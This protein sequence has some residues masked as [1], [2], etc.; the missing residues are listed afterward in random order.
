MTIGESMRQDNKFI[1][2]ID[3]ITKKEITGLN[4]K[5]T[6]LAEKES[7]KWEYDE[8]DNQRDEMAREEDRLNNTDPY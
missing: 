5:E 8:S 7:A 4:A 1:K 3:K 6:E 2:F